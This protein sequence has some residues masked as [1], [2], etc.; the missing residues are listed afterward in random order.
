[1]KRPQNSTQRYIQDFRDLEYPLP[2][3]DKFLKTWIYC[4]STYKK[5]VMNLSLICRPFENTVK[6]SFYGSI[7]TTGF[8]SSTW[9]L[10]S[11]LV[12]CSPSSRDV[13]IEVR[14]NVKCWPELPQLTM[15]VPPFNKWV[16]KSCIHLSFFS[17]MVNGSD[18]HPSAL[19]KNKALDGWFPVKVPFVPL[20]D[21]F[22]HVCSSHHMQHQK[23]K[24]FCE[25]LQSDFGF[26]CS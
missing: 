13:F 25:I 9:I 24:K 23:R 12:L 17:F 15:L 4:T 11:L 2:I 6:R 20:R 18:R 3:W 19:R 1:M 16:V 26:L 21:M 5:S 10:A 14:E 22:D 8:M 7:R